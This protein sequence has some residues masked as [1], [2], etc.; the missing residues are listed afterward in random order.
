LDRYDK[1]AGY[2]FQNLSSDD[3]SESLF[4]I[5]A[6]SGGGTRAAALSYG[7]LE[8]LRNTEIVWEGK[9]KSLLDEVDVISS[10]SGG[11]FTAAYYALYGDR[12][13]KDFDTRFLKKNIQGDLQARLYS[14]YNWYRLASL[15]LTGSTWPPS[16]MMS[17]SSTTTHSGTCSGTESGH[18]F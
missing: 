12:M 17:S 7:V 2:R 4:I 11:S 1:N 13:F 18:S 16:I 6:F 5:L 8:Q 3:N 9:R 15:P 14:P 10:V